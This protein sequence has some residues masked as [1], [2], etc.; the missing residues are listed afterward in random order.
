MIIQCRLYIVEAYAADTI[1]RRYS[2]I[3]QILIGVQMVKTT[4]KWRAKKRI[5]I[6]VNEI[7]FFSPEKRIF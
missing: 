1:Y 4:V 5:F 2:C 6:G 7:V 3:F